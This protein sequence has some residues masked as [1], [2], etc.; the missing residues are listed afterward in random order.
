MAHQQVVPVALRDQ[1]V[2]LFHDTTKR[3]GWG[4]MWG[5]KGGDV[6]EDHFRPTLLRAPIAETF[7]FEERRSD[8]PMYDHLVFKTHEGSADHTQA[9]E[10]GVLGVGVRDDDLVEVLAGLI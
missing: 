3:C 2:P 8:Q 6:L 7:G 1:T 10:L 5:C 9:G 4:S